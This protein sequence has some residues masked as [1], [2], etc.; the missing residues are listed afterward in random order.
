[1]KTKRRISWAN[2]ILAA[3]VLLTGAALAGAAFLLWPAYTNPQSRMY[4]SALGFLK[5][6]RLLGIQ[7]QAEAD[8]RVPR[9]RCPYPR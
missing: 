9:L 4:T 7:M 2:R 8:N 5:V 3:I 1:M 6:E